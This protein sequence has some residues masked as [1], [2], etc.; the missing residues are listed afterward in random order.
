[1]PGGLVELPPAS[2][3]YHFRWES[4]YACPLCTT[5]DYTAIVGEC[6]NGQRQ[7]VYTWITP[8]LC[9]DGAPLPAAAITPCGM[10]AND[11]ARVG[12]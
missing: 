5:D 11:P 12:N 1:M 8:R 2:C 3:W 4:L 6:V 7:T 10:C 9:H